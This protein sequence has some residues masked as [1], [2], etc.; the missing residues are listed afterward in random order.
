MVHGG[1]GEACAGVLM[2]AGVSCKFKM[3]GIPH[4]Y[5]VTGSQA[6]IYFHY[7]LNME[8]IAASIRSFL[9]VK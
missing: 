5:T 8:G 6:D 3:M 7:N 1:L 4:E 9:G 2:E